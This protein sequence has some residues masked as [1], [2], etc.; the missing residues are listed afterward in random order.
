[1]EA[2]NQT[3]G[4]EECRCRPR[5]AQAGMRRKKMMKQLTAKR[6]DDTAMHV[7]ACAG[8]LASMREMMSGK[9]AEELGALLSWPP[10]TGTCVALAAER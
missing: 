5:A 8:Q 7:A 6:D 9:V 2:K 10:G 1:M 3:G 4:G